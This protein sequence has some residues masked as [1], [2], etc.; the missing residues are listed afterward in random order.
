MTKNL[1]KN[2]KLAKALVTIGGLA[3]LFRPK[4]SG[5]YD[6]VSDM[7]I[8]RPFFQTSNML[9][10]QRVGCTDTVLHLVLLIPH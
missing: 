8:K 3:V 1:E 9:P 10:S 6:E 5:W 2:L 7:T 4:A